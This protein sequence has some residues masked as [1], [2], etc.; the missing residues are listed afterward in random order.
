MGNNKSGLLQQVVFKCR[1][2]LVDF[3][4]DVVSEQWS[5]KTVDCLI[6]VASKKG[7]TV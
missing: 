4:K 1:F 2:H 6:Q 3:R 7:L 5:H